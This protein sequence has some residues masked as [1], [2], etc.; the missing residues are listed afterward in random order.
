MFLLEN[1]LSVVIY[2]ASIFT[3]FYLGKYVAKK[4]IEEK[5]E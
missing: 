5:G 1:I 2:M 4:E 3:A